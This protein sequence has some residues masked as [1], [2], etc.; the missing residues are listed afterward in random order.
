MFSYLQSAGIDVQ[1]V[2]RK[3]STGHYIADFYVPE[4]RDPV[5]PAS[6]WARAIAQAGLRVLGTADT[7]ADWRPDQPVIC[8]T[9]TFTLA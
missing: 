4:M 2:E 3:R 8:A 5:P 6:T 9:V 1:K 7:V